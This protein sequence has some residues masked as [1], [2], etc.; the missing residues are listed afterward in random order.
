MSQ[1]KLT[2]EQED[3]KRV[4]YEQLNPRRKRFIDKIGYDKWDPFPEPFDPIDIRRDVSQ[5][6]LQDLVREFLRMRG[7]EMKVSTAYSKGAFDMAM[8]IMSRDDRHRGMYDFCVW[9]T[10]LLEQENRPAIDWETK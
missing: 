4:M 2:P 10:N 1:Q 9:Y 6:T 3:T 8:G 5:R 7:Q